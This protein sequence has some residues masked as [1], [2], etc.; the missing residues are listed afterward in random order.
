MGDLLPALLGLRPAGPSRDALARRLRGRVVVVTGASRGIGAEVARRFALVGARLV[1]LARDESALEAVASGIRRRG[2]SALVIAA[3]LR[4]PDAAGAAGDRILTEAGTPELVVS[5]AGHS[6]RRRL[7]DYADRPHDVTRTIGVNYVGPVALLQALVPAMAQAGRGHI[8]SIGST[9]IDIPAPGWS[10]YGASKTAFDAWLRAV[11]PELA[12]HGIAVTSIHLPLVRTAMS[13]P[14]Y[15]ASSPAMRPVD[16]AK[17]I[18]R[19]VVERPRLVS[20]WWSRLAGGVLVAFPGLSDRAL[21]AYDRMLE[22][23]SR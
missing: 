8:V 21:R 14:T 10:V 6:I 16:A 13:A 20:P 3:D 19:A 17:L 11:A 2:G 18:A 15:G 4:D 5:N 23:G 12:E 9:S 1:L 22:R 7:L